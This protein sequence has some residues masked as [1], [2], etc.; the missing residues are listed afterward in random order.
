MATTW[1]FFVKPLGASVGLPKSGR[2]SSASAFTRH[3]GTGQP[4]SMEGAIRSLKAAEVSS[5]R[6]VTRKLEW[7]GRG[8][9]ETSRRTSKSSLARRLSIWRP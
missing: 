3:S 4:A 6:P 2:K 9:Q 1:W 7:I 5:E 8:I